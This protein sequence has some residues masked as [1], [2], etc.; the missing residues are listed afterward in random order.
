MCLLLLKEG[1]RKTTTGDKSSLKLSA[2]TAVILNP[3][4]V[5]TQVKLAVFKMHFSRAVANAVQTDNQEE[6]CVKK[7]KM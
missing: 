3:L 1:K 5:K 2:E 6:C 4:Q 7:G